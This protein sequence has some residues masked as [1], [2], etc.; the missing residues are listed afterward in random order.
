MEVRLAAIGMQE[1]AV[2][3][4][5]RDLAGVSSSVAKVSASLDGVEEGLKAHDEQLS[6]NSTLVQS[7]SDSLDEARAECASAAEASQKLG[8]RATA[9]ES[10]VTVG[11]EEQR[12]LKLKAEEHDAALQKLEEGL[13]RARA[14]AS[15]RGAHDATAKKQQAEIQRLTEEVKVLKEMLDAFNDKGASATARCLSC[16]SR[17]SQQHNRFTVGTDGKAYFRTGN[18]ETVSLGRLQGLGSSLPLGASGASAASFRRSA[19]PTRSASPAPVLSRSLLGAS[20]SSL[21]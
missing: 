9:L 8:E 16:Y 17:R 11:L 20:A 2:E 3:A 18:G 6:A 14:E 13:A 19:S 10:E 12:G 21:L 7:L 5:R 4:L 1:Q 15:Q